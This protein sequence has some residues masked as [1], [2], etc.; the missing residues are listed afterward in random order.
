MR[1]HAGALARI[2][3]AAFSAIAMAALIAVPW[4]GS[5]AAHAHEG[6]DHADKPAA[7]AAALATPRVVAVSVSYQFVGIVEGEVLVV[8]LDRAADNAPVTS[9]T[10]KVTLNGQAFKAEP[11][12]NG[13]YEVTAPMLKQAGPIEVLATI[14]D[15]S[16]SDLLV[17]GLVIAASTPS[18]GSPDY[19]AL[20][21]GMP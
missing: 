13:T 9:A 10:I 5:D 18:R 8:Y 21:T 16:Q 15:A 6:H 3:R 7:G 20:W 17:G 1:P 14:V 2:C 11:Q 12:T 19:I 4:P